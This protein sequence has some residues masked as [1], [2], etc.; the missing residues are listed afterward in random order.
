MD[1][2][3]R[4]VCV[5]PQNVRMHNGVERVSHEARMMALWSQERAKAHKFEAQTYTVTPRDV[6]LY[7][8]G[9]SWKEA[10]WESI[11]SVR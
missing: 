9:G 1:M 7:A 11:S 10:M 3:S 8:L 4:V 5:Y 2:Q 6:I